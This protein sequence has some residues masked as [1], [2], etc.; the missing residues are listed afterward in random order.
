[1]KKNFLNN[2]LLRIRYVLTFLPFFFCGLYILS[3]IFVIND[4]F[5]VKALFGIFGLFLIIYSIY[6][7]FRKIKDIEYFGGV[8]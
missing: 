2:N 6:K 5:I 1:M 4:E 8:E 7:I 3:I